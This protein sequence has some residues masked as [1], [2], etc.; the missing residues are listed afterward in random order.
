MPYLPTYLLIYPLVVLP[1]K[2]SVKQ[3][4]SLSVYWLNFN[5]TTTSI[6][7]LPVKYIAITW[8]IDKLAT[9]QTKESLLLFI[10]NPSY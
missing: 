6:D 10:T 3:N 5:R 9:P 1:G 7:N 4:L 8:I 2:A